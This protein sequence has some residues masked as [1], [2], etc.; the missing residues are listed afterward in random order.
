MSHAT[1]GAAGYVH[2][3][4]QTGTI[5]EVGVNGASLETVLTL[6]M[7][8]LEGFQRGTLPCAE[9]EQ[10]LQQLRA[11]VAALEARTA[12]RTALGVEGTLRPH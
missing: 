10:A 9:N 12:K 7:R 5:P 11:A 1:D 8:R 6:V 2:I 3:K 4:W